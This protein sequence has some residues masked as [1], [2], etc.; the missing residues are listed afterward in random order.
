MG[1]IFKWTGITFGLGLILLVTTNCT[2]LGLNH[3]SLKTADKF[4]A[5]PSLSA[6]LI[7]RDPAARAALRGQ[8][9]DALYGPWPEGL[10]PRLV[11]HTVIDAAYHDGKA[12]LEEFLVEVGSGDG[13][14]KFHLVAVLPSGPG[15]HPIIVSQTFSNNCAVFPDVPVSSPDGSPCDG[16]PMA[17]PLGFAA[18]QMFGTYIATAPTDW[19]VDAGIGYASFYASQLVPDRKALAPGVMANLGAD[20]APTSALM[21]WA[22]GFSIAIGVLEADPRIDASRTGVMGHS[23]HG[24]SALIAGAW[25][26]RIDLVIAHQS[27]FG[28][29]SLSASGTGER[30]DRMAKTYPHWTRPGLYSDLEAG[31]EMPVDQHQLLALIAPTPVLLGNGRRDVWSDPNSSYR[32]VQAAAPAYGVGELPTRV[33]YDGRDLSPAWWLRSGGHSVIEEDI[34]AF[35]EFTSDNWGLTHGDTNVGTQISVQSGK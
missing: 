18:T 2:M 19:Y 35:I 33:P 9:E 12:T 24:K 25:D 13:A 3:A 17:S 29:A 8:F 15:P 20:V 11:S 10:A 14:R 32:A 1:K 26:E 6:G 5:T 16:S 7:A 31:E 30:L 23:R 27:G 34:R 21:A 28:G 4:A 22:G